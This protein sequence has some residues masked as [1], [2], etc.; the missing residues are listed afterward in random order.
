MIATRL[1]VLGLVVSTVG[2]VVWCCLLPEVSPDP[3]T[4]PV[5]GWDDLSERP[6][7]KR[8]ASDP[9]VAHVVGAIMH[10]GKPV[11]GALIEATVFPTGM[12]WTIDEATTTS[13]GTFSLVVTSGDLTK[14]QPVDLRVHAGDMSGHLTLMAAPRDTLSDVRIEVGVGVTVHGKIIDGDGFP[15]TRYGTE[16]VAVCLG[17]SCGKPMDDGSF[18]LKSVELGRHRFHVVA[19]GITYLV[20]EL[21]L[22]RVAPSVVTDHLAGSIDNIVL[23]V[24][25]PAARS[26]YTGTSYSA[27]DLGSARAR[28]VL[29]R[30]GALPNH[31]DCS[32]ENGGQDVPAVALTTITVPIVRRAGHA[33]IDCD[34]DDFE[35]IV[36]E[37]PDTSR[38]IDLPLVRHAFDA[39]DLGAELR[40]EASGARVIDVADEAESAGL[41][42]NDIVTAIDGIS[43][44]GLRIPTVREL[45]FRLPPGGSTTWTI[46]RGG[47][48]VTIH[49]RA[50]SQ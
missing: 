35:S 7:L 14:R 10:E 9:M 34:V 12:A 2:V 50:P 28:L 45:G 5:G 46:R 17:A 4:E 30:G 44:A 49:A 29:A 20:S 11:A 42:R 6:P 22:T 13:D 15:V 21:A 19:G 18:T 40:T 37:D 47:E 36:I 25:G 48:V 23:H 33:L 27:S 31:L 1:K 24:D 32:T 38:V 8:S 3:R 26:K 16:P 41:Q 39:I 43:I